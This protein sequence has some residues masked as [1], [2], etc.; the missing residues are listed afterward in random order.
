[1]PLHQLCLTVRASL[2]QT[3]PVAEALQALLTP[4]AAASVRAALNDLG[5]IGAFDEGNALT[6]LGHHLA[7]MPMDPKLGKALVYGAMLR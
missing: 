3:I 1:M 2:P 6:M 7:Q 4:P 5:A